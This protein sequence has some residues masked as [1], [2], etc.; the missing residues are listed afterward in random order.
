MVF[1]KFFNKVII[2]LVI[3]ISFVFVKGL[4][5]QEA[6]ENIKNPEKELNQVGTLQGEMMLTNPKYRIHIVTIAT[7]DDNGSNAAN[8]TASKIK[9]QIAIVNQIFS[10]ANIEFI[11]SE[12]TDFLRINSTL[13]NRDFTLLELPNVGND[14]WDHEPLRDGARHGEARAEIARQFPGK[15]VVFF[16]NRK[17]ID[18]DEAGYW[19]IF[20]AG[21]SSSSNSLYVALSPGNANH[22]A[23]EIGH[24]T[25]LG[26][27]FV[28]DVKTVADAAQKIK[29]YVEAGHPQS[30]GLDALDGDRH[31]VLDTPADCAGNI[32]KDQGLDKCG[33][34][35]EIPIPVTFSDNTKK[36]YI[37]APDRS[38]IISYFFGC[39]GDK[40]ISPQQ[41]RRIR[42]GL[43]LRLRHDLLNIKPSFS[44]KIVLKAT[45]NAGAI[46]E[47][48]IALVREGRVAT[49]V[50]DGSN[51]LK[52]IIWDIVW[53]NN[54][55]D[56]GIIRRGSATAGVVEKVSICSL[57]LN[58]LATTVSNNKI[59]IWRVNEDGSVTRLS[60]V[61]LAGEIKH[62]TSG[63]ITR[64]YMATASWLDKS[65]MRLDIWSV[66][67]DG[68]I[69][70]RKSASAGPILSLGPVCS[71]G[72]ESLVTFVR[73]SDKKLKAILWQY[74]DN[75]NL[76]IRLGS[77]TWDSPVR[78]FS[79]CTVGRETCTAAIQE[80]NSNN[81][82]LIAFRCRRDG[83]YIENLGLAEAGP[84]SA[85]GVCRLGTEMVVTGVRTGSKL[86]VILWHITPGGHQ[87]V[88][89]SDATFNENF[90]RL[91]MCQTGQ[92]NIVTAI[93]DSKGELKVIVWRIQGTI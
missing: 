35:G 31:W 11:F 12:T 63:L 56:P 78:D 79:G 72:A 77:S 50:R 8:I 41:A 83:Q 21:G 58:M 19:K 52:I 66:A 14:R 6:D 93:R 34:V 18:K 42:D 44:D 76:L 32:F 48:D 69:T 84:I 47:L 2:V 7:A 82:K 53:D 37:L 67:A 80:E 33:S 17:K 20:N 87:V 91:A 30:A 28:G 61:V 43:E 54:T 29:K 15:L 1:K 74:I 51:N 57:G 27:T 36:T 65:M 49:L 39:P 68:S 55:G 90:S 89:L 10:P 4:Q 64:H 73:D 81:L 86:K 85:V 26:H 38:L 62:V 25:Q 24:Y 60:D 16:C 9:D 71:I 3:L 70:L 88:R 5:Y 40:T 23:H 22:L 75:D 59:I 45:G 92:G 13:L 46:S